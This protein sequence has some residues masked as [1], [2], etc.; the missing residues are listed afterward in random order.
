MTMIKT[1]QKPDGKLRRQQ[2]SEVLTLAEAAGYLRV[3]E[4]AVLQL[5][6]EQCLPGRRIGD[7]WR[8]AR[9]ALRDWLCEGPSAKD[10]IM[11]LAR[12]WK[13]DPHLEAIV[14]EAYRRRR[15]IAGGDGE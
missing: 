12:A 15:Q 8:F 2:P 14:R 10:R 11:R 4:E 5:V 6:R 3:S 13:D 9:T 1:K 7:E